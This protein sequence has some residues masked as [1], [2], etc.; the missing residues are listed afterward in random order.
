MLPMRRFCGNVPKGKGREETVRG[1]EK[2]RDEV[3]RGLEFAI[4]LVSGS[5]VCVCK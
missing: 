3:I 5:A 1:T 4:V 2:K